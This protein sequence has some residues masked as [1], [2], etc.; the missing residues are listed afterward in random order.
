MN[1]TEDITNWGLRKPP[2]SSPCLG[3]M[4]RHSVRERQFAHADASIVSRASFIIPGIF[5]YVSF[6]YFQVLELTTRASVVAA[7]V[8]NQEGV[9]IKSADGLPAAGGSFSLTTLSSCPGAIQV[10]FVTLEFYIKTVGS[11][12]HFSAQMCT[13][14]KY[15]SVHFLRLIHNQ[16]DTLK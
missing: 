6:P 1:N 5:L 14:L 12:S 9:L 4:K 8:I 13:T 7:C 15:T 3:A 2:N 16:S 10:S 11:S